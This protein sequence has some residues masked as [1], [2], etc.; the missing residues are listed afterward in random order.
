[1]DDFWI[2]R[3]RVLLESLCMVPSKSKTVETNLN[4]I[5]R[6]IFIIALILYLI[7]GKH[8]FIYLALALTIIIIVYYSVVYSQ[9]KTMNRPELQENFQIPTAMDS[10]P[11]IFQPSRMLIKPENAD[12]ATGVHWTVKHG[13]PNP[14]TT[15]PIPIAPRLHDNEVWG[16]N[17]YIR[18]GI[19]ETG[20][21]YMINEPGDYTYLG[22]DELPP[23]GRPA[24]D[25]TYYRAPRRFDYPYHP[26]Q[27]TR[28]IDM[29]ATFPERQKLI[30]SNPIKPLRAPVTPVS[31]AD[32]EEK[33]YYEKRKQ[34]D[35]L[36]GMGDEYE[37]FENYINENSYGDPNPQPKTPKT[38]DP[39]VYPS[40]G[41]PEYPNVYSP[42]STAL[43]QAYAGKLN[44]NAD[45]LHTRQT[46]L[47]ST[48]SVEG[49]DERFIHSNQFLH[50]RSVS[51]PD[52]AADFEVIEPI[53][54]NIGV[55]FNSQHMYIDNELG[56]TNLNQ[57]TY[58]R[59][60]PQLIRNPEDLD[61][62]RSEENPTRNRWT[63]KHSAF[64]APPGSIPL[65]NIYD[66]RFTGA[67]DSYRSYEDLNSGRIKYYYRNVEAYKYPLFITRNAVDHVDLYAENGEIW[68]RYDVKNRDIRDYRKVANDD[69]MSSSLYHREDLMERQ[70]RKQNRRTWQLRMAPLRRNDTPGGTG[71]I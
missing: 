64:E 14:K 8:S 42:T 33:E 52:I 65:E 16:N 21:R 53:N 63:Q 12:F 3:P 57:S 45:R 60:D 22:E 23:I 69:F 18:S 5:T 10:S 15:V 47:P 40:F 41:I 71:R 38:R 7:I 24:D 68:P 9:R 54:A 25:P 43:D 13:K 30:A 29:H 34:S 56:P 4:C 49:K 44:P 17:G 50:R 59:W 32:D 31:Y 55:T 2:E 19:N 26:E 58:T 28:N 61:V 67:G 6:L 62:N 27:T 70:M 35:K 20:T 48:L 51:N 46:N 39:K 36:S 66:P 37:P 1:M 11:G